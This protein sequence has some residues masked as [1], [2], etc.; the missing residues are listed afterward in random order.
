M[1]IE[2][3]KNYSYNSSKSLYLKTYHGNKS[4]TKLDKSTKTR[5]CTA[6]GLRKKRY[7]VVDFNKYI[8]TNLDFKMNKVTENVYFTP[9]NCFNKLAGKYYSSSNNVHIKN[10]RNKRKKILNDYPKNN[11][12]K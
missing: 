1:K 10:K 7:N 5:P 12:K 4:K 6:I 11:T 3:K 2:N 9:M 8:D